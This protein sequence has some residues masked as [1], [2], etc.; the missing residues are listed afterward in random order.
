[1]NCKNCEKKISDLLDGRFSDKQKSVLENHLSQ[2]RSC[3][4]YKNQLMALRSKVRG[5]EKNE[6]PKDYA[7]EFSIRLKRRLLDEQ[8]KEK[9][10]N[11]NRFPGFEKWA[12]S[13]AGFIVVL[14]L[15]L[16]FVVFQPASFQTDEY[17]VLS[18]EDAIGGLI[19]EIDNDPE[20]EELFNKIILASLTEALE[21]LDEETIPFIIENPF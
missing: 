15:V 16:C 1:M 8:H 11:R 13:A 21:D 5:R 19:G 3:K 12:Y 2:C 4:E 20:L 9:K 14:F 6:M 18:F 10:R 17:F 7:L